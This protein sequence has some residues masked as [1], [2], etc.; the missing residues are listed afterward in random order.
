MTGSPLTI[1]IKEASKKKRIVKFVEGN[2]PV[3]K[4]KEKK[5]LRI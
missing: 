1:K 4:E 2:E 5:N 3:K